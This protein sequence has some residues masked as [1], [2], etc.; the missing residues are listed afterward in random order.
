MKQQAIKLFE[1]FDKDKYSIQ[2]RKE[3][4]FKS[5]DK[6]ITELMCGKY[7]DGIEKSFD[8]LNKIKEEIIKL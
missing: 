8:N 7:Y 3:M 2:E 6:V 4:C 1:T 5:I